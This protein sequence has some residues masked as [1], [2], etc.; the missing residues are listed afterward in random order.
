MTFFLC[1]L[2]FMCLAQAQPNF[3]T[4]WPAGTVLPA[5]E[6]L[7]N[8]AQTAFALQ[9]TDGNFCLYRGTGPANNLGRVKCSAVH[10]GLGHVY[11][12]SMLDNGKLCTYQN[13]K[14]IWCYKN[15]NLI[16]P[17]NFSSQFYFAI[18]DDGND[19]YIDIDPTINAVVKLSAVLVGN[20]NIPPASV[21]SINFDTLLTNVAPI[22]FVPGSS[23]II[24]VGGWYL[25][26]FG[27]DWGNLDTGVRSI[28]PAVTGPN[29]EFITGLVT[30]NA[31]QTDRTRQSSSFQAQLMAGDTVSV[32][33]WQTN[34]EF[35]EASLTI[36]GSDFGYVSYL[37]LILLSA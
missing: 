30:E 36:G 28:W 37:Q 27:V 1:L 12:A 35:P 4:R 31:V 8:T 2:L 11:S 19:W 22:P 13:G 9:Q 32:N 3:V 26:T 24:P 21:A 29:S 6:I 33:V 14:A 7:F 5:G 17:P 34:N 16:N 15:L 10:H 23:F 20:Q 25:I 18:Q